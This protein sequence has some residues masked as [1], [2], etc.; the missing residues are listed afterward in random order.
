MTF[1]NDRKRII[2]DEV[3]EELGDNLKAKALVAHHGVNRL[4]KNLMND[5][6]GIA[7]LGM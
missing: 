3:H 6:T 5:F 4:T 1:D 7:W 2:I